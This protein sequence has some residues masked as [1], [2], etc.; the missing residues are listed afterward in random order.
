MTGLRKRQV[1]QP[2]CK[3]F[4][5]KQPLLFVQIIF[6]NPNRVLRQQFLYMLFKFQIYSLRTNRTT[7]I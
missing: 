1:L 4:I 7:P 5:N 6:N 2:K 3:K